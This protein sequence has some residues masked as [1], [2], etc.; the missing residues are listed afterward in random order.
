MSRLAP[1]RAAAITWFELSAAETQCV[2]WTYWTQKRRRALIQA[3]GTT[4]PYAS[5]V[6]RTTNG[7]ERSTPPEPPVHTATRVSAE[8]MKQ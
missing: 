1:P 4:A 3:D 2:R 7:V 6:M 8:A 5:S